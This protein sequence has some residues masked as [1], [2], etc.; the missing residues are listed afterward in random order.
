MNAESDPGSPIAYLVLEPGTPVV[1]SEGVAV[2]KVGKVLAV[3][4]EDV[5]DGIVI[6]TGSGTRFID[7]DQIGRLYERRAEL[8]ITAEQV[9][10]Q[11]AHEISPGAYEAGVEER[12]VGKDK[13][14]WREDGD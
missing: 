9:A 14:G 1:D 10:S 4:D 6:D 7:A 12:R 5:F 2:G 8:N 3:P 13:L 11:P